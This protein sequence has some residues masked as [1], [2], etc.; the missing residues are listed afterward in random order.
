MACRCRGGTGPRGR[1]WSDDLGIPRAGKDCT[2]AAM[3]S[4]RLRRRRACAAHRVSFSSGAPGRPRSALAA[5]DSDHDGL[6]NTWER[7]WSHTNPYREDTNG[8]GIADGREDPDHDGLSNRQRVPGRDEPAQSRH[9]RDGI[10]T[11]ARIPTTTAFERTEFRAGT[12]PRDADSDNDGLRD[13]IE[14]TR[15]R[16]APNGIEQLV[17]TNPAVA[18]SNHDGVPDGSED[19]DADGLTTLQEVVRADPE[20]DAHA[21][22]HAD[23]DTDADPDAD[24][25]LDAPT[26]AA[27][28]ACPIFP[29]DNVWNKPVDTLPVAANS[30]TMIGAIGL[31]RR[32]PSGLQRVR[33]LR[34]PV[35]GRRLRDAVV[36]RS[37]STT[38]TNPT[39]GLPDPGIAA[40]RGRLRRPHPHGRHQD[41]CRLYEL[42]DAPTS[43]AARGRPAPGATWD[44][45]SNALRPDGWTSADAA[46]LPILPGP[47]ALRR[48]RRRRDPPRAAVHGPADLRQAYIF[49]ATTRG[50]VIVQ[51]PRCHRWASA[52]GSRRRATS[53]GFSPAGAGD[54]GSRSSATG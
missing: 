10:E 52:C 37:R 6:P 38:T 16:R 36:R 4:P 18:D 48:G 8:N 34:H 26:S 32:P 35:P 23:A 47:R 25:D 40:H 17:G 39:V 7:T 1:R 2:I 44:L 43:R 15:R 50:V 42:F 19:P 31:D 5:T 53:T 13:G 3:D 54:R 24:A 51:R 30:A 22:A 14:G 33:G 46:G 11:G 27:A 20:A 9:D 12:N 29:A 21:D 45:R 28:P 49:P 41:A